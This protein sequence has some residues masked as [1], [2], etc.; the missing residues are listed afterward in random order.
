MLIT[1]VPH[2]PGRAYRLRLYVLCRINL[3]PA[4]C[5]FGVVERISSEICRKEHR[6]GETEEI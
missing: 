2:A 1:V 3:L 5:R 4:Y 6:N